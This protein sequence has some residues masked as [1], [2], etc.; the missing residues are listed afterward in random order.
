[1]ANSLFL[2]ADLTPPVELAKRIVARLKLNTVLA[3]Y[4]A[5]WGIGAFVEMPATNRY[6]L[7]V[8]MVLNSRETDGT[9]GTIEK[10]YTCQLQIA[11]QGVDGWSFDADD[12]AL[13]PA[14]A[15]ATYLLGE[16]FT[17]LRKNANLRLGDYT[18]PTSGEKIIRVDLRRDDKVYMPAD[19]E[20]M[21][22]NTALF[23]FDVITTKVAT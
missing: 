4:V 14:F 22:E 19:R 12:I 15:N 8:V 20:L 6:P 11:I 5:G 2:N 13:S 7:C 10:A 1:M 17:E 23:S 16:A 18:L 3:Q 9:T 21:Y